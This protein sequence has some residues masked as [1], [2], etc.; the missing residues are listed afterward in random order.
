MEASIN[1]QSIADTLYQIA[2]R[3]FDV[4]TFP[5][6]DVLQLELKAQNAR[7]SAAEARINLRSALQT[8]SNLTGL[9][10]IGDLVAPLE[11]PAI[12]ISIEEA[13]AQALK[14]RSYSVSNDRALVDAAQEMDRAK[15]SNGLNVVLQG[16]FGLSQTGSQLGDAY[17]GLL[18]QEELN[19]S[20]QVPIADWGKAKANKALAASNYEL[21]KTQNEQ[22]RIQAEREIIVSAEQLGLLKEKVALAKRSLEIANIRSEITQQR[23]A[24][25]TETIVELNLALESA[26]K[27]SI[28]ICQFHSSILD[29]VLHLTT[30]YPY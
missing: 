3:R 9:Q 18:D 19:L 21:V 2:T 14:N 10:T 23:Y 25:G 7:V 16:S 17:K 5:K 6:T 8:L 22:V 20:L 24:I 27:R 15:K 1:N 12:E 26:E 30:T 4:G 29:R 28:T 11:I 13:L